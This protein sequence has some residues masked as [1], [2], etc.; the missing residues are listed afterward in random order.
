MRRTIRFSGILAAALFVAAA[1]TLADEPKGKKA[2]AA[3]MDE[4]AAMDAMMKAGAPGDAHKKLEA[5]TGTWDAKVTSWMAPGKPPMESKGKSE[6]KMALGG[7]FLEERFEGEFMGQPFTGMGYTGY[8]NVQKKYVGTWMD[9]MSTGVMTS[10]GKMDADGKTFSMTGSMADPMTGK[11][12]TVKEKVT[13]ADPD[14]HTFEMWGA[15]PGGK[16]FKMMEI[17][18]TRRK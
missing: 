4:K 6:A 18:Y 13:V 10:S 17:V 15:G 12:S 9:S 2:A 7:R 14:H 16:N 3:P 1:L 5:L 8:D 11:M